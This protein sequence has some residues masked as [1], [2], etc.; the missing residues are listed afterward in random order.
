MLLALETCHLCDN[1]SDKQGELTNVMRCH[2]QP[3]STER[4]ARLNLDPEI[5]ERMGNLDER[6]MGLTGLMALT[7]LT[8]LT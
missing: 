7:E 2:C 3:Q 8:E 6:V 1:C 5:L 4:S